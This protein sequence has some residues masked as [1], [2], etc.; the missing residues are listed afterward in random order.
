MS[1]EL[2][3]LS[4]T[5]EEYVE[6]LCGPAK[7]TLKKRIVDSCLF[8]ILFFPILNLI[9]DLKTLK[10]QLS[11]DTSDII[12]IWMLFLL[13]SLIYIMGLVVCGAAV[14]KFCALPSVN[15]III[16]SIIVILISII[17]VPVWVIRK[18]VNQK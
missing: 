14:Y 4:D 12:C 9:D 1:K 15:Q 17:A 5:C 8:S 7:P 16:A 18:W 10:H 2:D 13:T 6:L 3:K 11:V